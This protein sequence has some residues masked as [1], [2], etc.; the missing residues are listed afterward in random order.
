MPAST[1]ACSERGEEYFPGAVLLDC[2]SPRAVARSSRPS[3]LIGRVRS[4][5]TWQHAPLAV[6]ST[7][8]GAGAGFGPGVGQHGIAGRSCLLL[9]CDGPRCFMLAIGHLGAP[10][11]WGIRANDTPV[12]VKTNIRTVAIAS[13]RAFI[14]HANLDATISIFA[15]ARRGVSDFGHNRGRAL[16]PNYHTTE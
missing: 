10:L 16:R 14:G 11:S 15:S 13:R 3:C 2:L 4:S 8:E 5:P 6:H 7:G 1:Q 12:L 9:S